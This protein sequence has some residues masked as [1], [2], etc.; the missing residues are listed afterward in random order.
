IHAIRSL[1][2]SP[3]F[4]LTAILTIALGLGAAT[5]IFSVA[6]AVLL[7]PLPYKEP[8]RLVFVISE[9]TRR[10][11][12]EFPFADAS[13]IDLRNGTKSAWGDSAAMRT[14]GGTVPRDDNTPEQIPFPIASPN[15]FRPL[16][17]P[18]ALGRDFPEADGEA[19]PPQ[20]NAGQNAAAVPGTPSMVILSHE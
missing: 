14:G 7:R 3:L 5:A 18:I 1:R 13:Y 10:N 12:K 9:M 6:N 15:T 17:A 2:R 8:S 11:V 4:A 19:P 20:P 16:G